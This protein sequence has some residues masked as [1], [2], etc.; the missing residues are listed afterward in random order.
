MTS[1]FTKSTS[2]GTRI[3][4]P[5]PVPRGSGAISGI[6]S[7]GTLNQ[8]SLA[9]VLTSSAQSNPQTSGLSAQLQKSKPLNNKLYA[10]TATPKLLRSFTIDESLNFFEPT[11]ASG[12][13]TTISAYDTVVGISSLKP[14]II[15][16]A[17]FIPLYEDNGLVKTPAGNSIDLK[18]SALLISASEALKTI[19]SLPNTEKDALIAKLEQNRV[20]INEFCKKISGSALNIFEIIELFKRDADFRAYTSISTY[21]TLGAEYKKEV[22]LPPVPTEILFAKSTDIQ[23]WTN[24]KTWVRACLELKE[25][26]KFG[27]PNGLLSD[28]PS[29]AP[30]FKTSSALSLYRDPYTLLSPQDGLTSVSSTMPK[31][32]FKNKQSSTDDFASARTVTDQASFN[33]FVSDISS[34]FNP[35]TKS[36]TPSIFN[37]YLKGDAKTQE[38]STHIARMCYVL[39]KEYLF[40]KK[41]KD[42]K[43]E[44]FTKWKTKA[45]YPGALENT[46]NYEFWDY[47]IGQAGRDI[48]DVPVQLGGTN[49]S[50]INLAQ[51][52]ET[53]TNVLN[54]QQSTAE[55]L[56]FENNYVVD[57]LNTVRPNVVMTPGS[58]F[59]LESSLR[60]LAIQQNVIPQNLNNF[61]QKLEDFTAFFDTLRKELTFKSPN[62][63]NIGE[64]INASE[65]VSP[66]VFPLEDPI[67]LFRQITN[68]VLIQNDLLDRK[69]SKSLIKGTTKNFGPALLREATVNR[70]ILPLLFIYTTGIMNQDFDTTVATKTTNFTEETFNLGSQ[71]GVDNLPET[72]TNITYKEKIVKLLVETLAK[73]ANVN[74]LSS[75]GKYYKL[76]DIEKELYDKDSETYAFFEMVSTAMKNLLI[77]VLYGGTDADAYSQSAPGLNRQDYYTWYSSI[78]RTS[79]FC[80]IFELICYMVNLATDE[81]F[82]TTVGNLFYIA[83]IRDLKEVV[84]IANAGS[85]KQVFYA[86]EFETVIPAIEAKL[87]EENRSFKLYVEKF[88]YFL[89][90]LKKATGNFIDQFKPGSYASPLQARTL[91]DAVNE[92]IPDPA[93]RQLLMSKEQLALVRSKLLYIIDRTNTSYSS[94]VKDNVYLKTSTPNP[95]LDLFLPLEDTHFCAWEY[96]L[97]DFFNKQMYRRSAGFNKKIASIALP[98]GLVRRLSRVNAAQYGVGTNRLANVIKVNIYRKDELRPGLVHKPLSFYFDVD[99]YPKR[100]LNNYIKGTKEYT[101]GPD[102][103]AVSVGAYDS[104]ASSLYDKILTSNQKQQL[105]DNHET[106]FKLEEYLKFMTSAFFDEQ[107]YHQYDLIKGTIES[108]FEKF[109]KS[110]GLSA[111]DSSNDP[112]AKYYDEENLLSNMNELKRNLI[113]PKKYDRVFHVIFDPDDFQVDATQTTKKD[114]E[115]FKDVLKKNVNENEAVYA[116]Q[117]TRSGDISFDSYY[118]EVETVAQKVQ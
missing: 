27:L 14:E 38:I 12:T 66:N 30:S 79:L 20:E 4:T 82:G 72:T 23:N 87:W 57:N 100:I 8:N 43:G 109:K 118:I 108:E 92:A 91:F 34:L 93:I 64:F 75:S 105:Y 48:T 117:Q 84:L 70:S 86:K 47:T 62:P 31:F 83:K 74:A 80:G 10:S 81:I 78:S 76:E 5:S 15:S 98:Q 17:D 104:K 46:G 73:R 16:L 9:T 111:T 19:Q 18:Q 102:A 45:A 36:S 61:D 39:S 112:S 29:P 55:V 13:S 49:F 44:A 32:G 97:K 51:T 24:T 99:K 22:D 103:Y 113:T 89:K 65:T 21:Q 11:D 6:T 116:R 67:T 71:A 56:A 94:A 58:Y 107:R 85:N 35:P 42:V 90:R 110:I 26:L 101:A 96:L 95:Y 25:V 63:R 114:L 3:S 88:Y 50:A 115:L 59:Y 41:L 53:F 33:Q 68:L 28:N 7:A 52:Q 2:K 69:N 40:S 54:N 1:I 106:S 77:P 60:S 37:S